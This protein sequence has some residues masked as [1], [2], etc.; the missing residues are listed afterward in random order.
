[1]NGRL[2][3]LIALLASLW[4]APL[5]AQTPPT[6]VIEYYHVDALGS[7]RAVRRWRGCGCGRTRA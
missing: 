3:V 5:W 2:S 6:G 4:G 1:M 7:V